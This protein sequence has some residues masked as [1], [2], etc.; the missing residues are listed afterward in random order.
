MKNKVK[1]NVQIIE[2]MEKQATQRASTRA[3]SA[4][5]DLDVAIFLFLIMVVVIILLFQGIGIEIVAPIATFGLVCVW[6]VGWQRGKKLYGIFYEEELS[7]LVRILSVKAK[8]E[9][10]VQ[11]TFEE[12]VEECVQK[13]LREGWDKVGITN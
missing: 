2:E 9:D 8:K 6:L 1:V 10:T 4:R 11:K 7:N 12:T 3:R 5:W 13:A